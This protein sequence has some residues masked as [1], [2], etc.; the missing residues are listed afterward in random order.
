MLYW[1]LCVLY[2]VAAG[3]D[4]VEGLFFQDSGCSV[5]AGRF[6]LEA[7][8][9]ARCLKCQ[10]FIPDNETVT[11]ETMTWTESKSNDTASTLASSSSTPATAVTA[12]KTASKPTSATNTTTSSETN[13]TNST[14]A[15]VTDVWD[16]SEMA[17]YVMGVLDAAGQCDA[18]TWMDVSVG[19]A[20][21][22]PNGSE[23]AIELYGGHPDS[24]EEWAGGYDRLVDKLTDAAQNH[25][26]VDYNTTIPSAPNVCREVGPGVYTVLAHSTCQ[27]AP[28]LDD[29]ITGLQGAVLGVLVFFCLATGG[30]AFFA[31]RVQKGFPRFQELRDNVEREKAQ[32]MR[33]VGQHETCR[34]DLDKNLKLT[35]IISTEVEQVTGSNQFSKG[36]CGAAIGVAPPTL[37]LRE[38][39]TRLAAKEAEIAHEIHMQQVCER[40]AML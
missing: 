33:V 39:L 10:R 8:G 22:S 5:P 35:D 18:C 15:N 36:L 2:T 16:S 40:D 11:N 34:E 26:A 28:S 4:V 9:V 38:E 32:H 12:T 20:L 23:F 37:P 30:V 27:R 19:M 3:H 1:V 6:V 17:V 31:W 29:S 25:D 14:E 21:C 13:S 24:P 7:D